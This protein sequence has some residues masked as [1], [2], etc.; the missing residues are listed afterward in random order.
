MD[1]K[2][3]GKDVAPLVAKDSGET[4]MADIRQMLSNFEKSELGVYEMRTAAASRERIIKTSVLGILAFLAV[5][6]L[7]VSNSYSFVLVRRQLVKLEGVETRI[8]SIIENIL[9]GMI[10]VDENGYIC[11][12]NPAAEKMFGYSVSEMI[13]YK[14]TKLVPKSYGNEPDAKP[15]PC[16]WEQMAKRTGSTTLALGRTRKLVSFPLEISLS[17]MEVDQQKFYVAMV[18]D[19]TERKRFEK[20]I[21]AEKESLAV[22][23]RSIG[24]GVITTDVQGKIIILNNEAERLTGWSSRE[25]IGQPLKSVFNVAMDLAAQARAQKSGYRNEAHSILLKSSRQCDAD[26]A[27]WQRTRHRAG[28]LAYS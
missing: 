10:T 9:D 17:Q 16:A 6:L 19:V 18:R 25:A 20:E 28:R 7:V 2:R 27:R 15:V 23:L 8:R 22:T 13:G 1:A 11:S 3:A 14:F 24:D 5:G 12:L 21:A 4:L 26:R